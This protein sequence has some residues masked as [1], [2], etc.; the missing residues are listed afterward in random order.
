MSAPPCP[1]CGQETIPTFAQW[2][3][4]DCHLKLTSAN[5]RHVNTRGGYEYRGG[6]SDWLAFFKTKQGQIPPTEGMRFVTITRVRGPGSGQREL[7]YD[8]LVGGA[9]SV[10]DA[11]KEAKL[12]RDDSPKFVR[13][14]YLQ[15]KEAK[16]CTRF[17]IGEAA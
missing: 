7:D 14:R 8:N 9:K 16:A 6:K 11:M 3:E 2:W 13:V 17:V 15:A 4:F 5:S 12:I 1:T 10:L